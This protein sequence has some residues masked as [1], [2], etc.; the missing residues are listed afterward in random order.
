MSE[1]EATPTTD[2]AK[3]KPEAPKA[4]PDAKP[5]DLAA[6]LE[7]Q[8]RVNRDLE[9]KLNA[10]RDEQKAQTAALAKALGADQEQPSDV[11]SLASQVET[12]RN[13]FAETQ[14]SNAVLATAQQFGITEQAD[15]DLLGK[16]PDAD[17]MRSLAQRLAA[18]PTAPGTPK[19]D[20]TQGGSATP[21]ALNSDALTDALRAA[22]GA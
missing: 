21:P 16:A 19:P 13:Q 3:P 9:T 10:L 4:K 17:T 7:A 1:N 6:K 2:A 12:L 20:A 22:V 18:Q 14:H 5:D 11:Q 15:L 8:Q